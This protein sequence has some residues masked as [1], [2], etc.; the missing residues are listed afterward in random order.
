M[1]NIATVLKAEIVRLARKELRSEV[2]TIKKALASSRSE[3]AALK[4]RVSEVERALRQLR[5]GRA[6]T[7]P[8]A[9]AQARESTE[10]FR[11]RPAGM[12][13]NR[14]RLGLS[15]A[16]FALLIGASAPSVYLWEQGKS[17]PSPKMISAIASIRGIGKR[18]ASARLAAI[19]SPEAP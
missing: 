15:A 19:K 11:F 7:S 3:N 1:P 8:S 2:E 5:T 12:A 17:R 13:S 9:S 16:D 18:E 6:S 4:R 14:A 10:S